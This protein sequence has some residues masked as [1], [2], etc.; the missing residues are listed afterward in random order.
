MKNPPA[1]STLLGLAAGMALALPAAAEYPEKPVSFVVPW[2]PGGE[3]DVLTRMIADE[4]QSMYGV[5]AAVVNKPG[6][7]GGPFPGAM[8]VASASADG[9]TIGSFVIGVPVVG[10]TLG[11]PALDPDPF[12]PVGVFLTYP[13]LIVAGQDAPYDS[14]EELAEYAQDN[15]VTLG[16]FGAGLV[17]TH[18]TFGLA[19]ELGFEFAADAAYDT[20]D[21][22]TLTS[23]DVDVMNSIAGL[24]KPCLSD[25]K[26]LASVTDERISLLPDTPTASEIDPDLD[27]VLWNGLF[28]PEGTPDD[29]I[30]K[31]EAAAIKAINSDKAKAY[32]ETNGAQIY[33]KDR[34]EAKELI[35]KDRETFLELTGQ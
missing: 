30:A 1:R 16:H 17:P 3:E 20:L 29:V 35:R 11:I 34:T 28:V 13:F 4:F 33:W 32:V 26:V 21:C 6:G 12:V 8:D 18:V 10:P 14:M 19:D 23:G 22:N 2:P 24:V 9:Y 5:P 15:D 7:G 31:I 27:I 25:I